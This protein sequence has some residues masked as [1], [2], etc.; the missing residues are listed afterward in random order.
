MKNRLVKSP[1]EQ[2]E[3][4]LS[5]RRNKTKTKGSQ[6]KKQAVEIRV[7]ACDM[8]TNPDVTV[9]GKPDNLVPVL[10]YAIGEIIEVLVDEGM[11]RQEAERAMITATQSAILVSRIEAE[12]YKNTIQKGEK[13]NGKNE[14]EI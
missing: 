6:T 3:E 10:A 2:A 11:K 8:E 13:S 14:S 4:I 1:Q 9:K 12:V 5:Q 7:T